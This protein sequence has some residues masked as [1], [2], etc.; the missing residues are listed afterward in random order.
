M[1]IFVA[2]LNYETQEESLRELFEEFGH[3]DSVKII[4]DRETGRSKGFALRK[5]S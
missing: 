1:N 5:W 4:M 2:R 3:V